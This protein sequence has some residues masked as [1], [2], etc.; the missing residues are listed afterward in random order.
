[1]EIDIFEGKATDYELSLEMERIAQMIS[2]G[3]NEGEIFS[4]GGGE[5]GEGYRGWWK[6]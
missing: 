4:D 5:D 3:Y 1:M 2:E 6:K